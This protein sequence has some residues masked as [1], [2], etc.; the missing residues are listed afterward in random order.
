MNSCSYGT[1]RCYGAPG[2][3]GGVL[4]TVLSIAKIKEDHNDGEHDR[5]VKLLGKRMKFTYG[6]I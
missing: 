3:T 5:T 2:R 4:G 1:V 6:E